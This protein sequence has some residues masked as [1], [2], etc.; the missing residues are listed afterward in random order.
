MNHL[1]DN[2]DFGSIGHGIIVDVG[3]SHGQVSIEIARKHPNVKCIIQD[4]AD[5]IAGLESRVPEDLKNRISGM[6]HDFLTPQPI[7]GADIYLLRWILHD[8]SDKYCVKI[9]HS[10]TPALRKGAKVVINDICI[11]Q[12]GQL[13]ISADRGLR[14]VVCLNL[15]S[16]T[17][18]Y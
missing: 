3:G 4:L 1:I 11:P 12:P 5:T 14:L 9:L 8:W 17:S 18:S 10:L 16:T 13:G 6:E 15:S 2:F 7:G